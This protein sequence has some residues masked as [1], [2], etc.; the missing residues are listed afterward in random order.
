MPIVEVTLLEGYDASVKRTLADRITRA[1][2]STIAAPLDGVLVAVHEVGPAGYMR[3]G[4]SAADAATGPKPGAPRVDASECV[5]AFLAAM[6][7]RDLEAARALLAPEFEMVFPGPTR[8]RALEELIE[9]AKPRYQS[10]GKRYDS[11]EECYGPTET[12]VWC[13]GTLHGVWLDGTPFDSIRFVDR[14]RLR[15]GLFVE[16]MVWNDLAETRAR[17]LGAT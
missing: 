14:F 13:Y 2:A 16:Q 3:G 1:V 17:L 10:V 11:F 5:R 7:R 9:W 8:M 4:R 15:D 6:A 12:V